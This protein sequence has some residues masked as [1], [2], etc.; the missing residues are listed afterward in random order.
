MNFRKNIIYCNGL[1]ECKKSLWYTGANNKR[2]CYIAGT[3][4]KKENVS[5][6]LG[7]RLFIR[8]TSKYP[9]IQSRLTVTPPLLT[10]TWM[11]Q[12]PGVRPT[13]TCW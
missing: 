1:K 2:S 12:S 7:A 6:S 11:Y 10:E 8:I 9:D 4:A 5:D 3:T 13:K